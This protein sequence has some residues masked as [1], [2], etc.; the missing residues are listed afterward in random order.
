[1]YEFACIVKRCVTISVCISY[2]QMSVTYLYS[3]FINKKSRQIKFVVTQSVQ[4]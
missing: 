3:V 1:M 2:A 4:K